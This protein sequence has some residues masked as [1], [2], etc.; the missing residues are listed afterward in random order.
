[1][2]K[3]DPL[4]QDEPGVKPGIAY[5]VATP[6]GNLKDIS[7]RA[8]DTLQFVDH[9]VVED[10]RHSQRLLT[11]LGIR[12]PLFVLHDHNEKQN[13]QQLVKI[14]QEGKSIALISDAGTPLISDP[15]F[16]LVRALHVLGIKV[17]PIPGACAAIAALSASG[18]PTD[19]FCFEGFLPAKK[20]ARLDQLQTLSQETRTLV[21]YEAPHRILETLEDMRLIFGETREAFFARELT[22]VFETLKS[23]TLLELCHWVKN[24][25]DQQRGEIVLLVEGNPNKNAMSVDEQEALRILRILCAEMSLSEAARLTAKISGLSKQ[26]LY[27]RGLELDTH[28]GNFNG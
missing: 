25:S 23:G 12:K 18:L 8:I 7:T 26:L 13:T 6:I 28:K 21:F 22:K 11:A 9:I 17:V 1:M 4:P 14:L 24:D 10:S 3:S 19:R 27:K 15:G 5:V 16:Y 2:K 20:K